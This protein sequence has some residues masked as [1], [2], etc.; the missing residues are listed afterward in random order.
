VVFTPERL[1][2]WDNAKIA[3]LRAARGQ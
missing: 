1:V 2:S 3:A